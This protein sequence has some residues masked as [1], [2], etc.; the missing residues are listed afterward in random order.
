[1]EDTALLIEKAKN[2]DKDAY[3]IL[4]KDYY[5]RIYRYC[6]VNLYREDIAEDVCQEVFIR[7]WKALH[8]FFLKDGGTFQAFLFRIARNLIIDLSRKKKEFSLETYQEIAVEEDFEE[9]LDKKDAIEKVKYALSKLSDADR[10][11]ILLRYF[12]ELNH[13]DVAKILGVKEGNVRV[14]TMRILQQLKNI[15]KK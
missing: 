9:K 15:L 2:G 13:A 5:G 12:E 10:Q 7:A 4:Y 6:K 11:L 3:G 1:M 8:T 14:K